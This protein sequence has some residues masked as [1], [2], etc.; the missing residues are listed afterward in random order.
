MASHFSTIGLAIASKEDFQALVQRICPLAEGLAAPGGVYWRWTDPC[1]A[2]VWIQVNEHNQLIGA[3][4]HYAGRSSVQVSLTARIPSPGPSELDGSFHGWAAPSGDAPD[5]GC[6]PFVFDAPDFRIHEGL[7]IPT[8]EAVQIAAFAHQIT[9]F[10]SVAAYEAGQSGNIPLYASQ[11]FIPSGLFTPA[12]DS[13]KPPLAHAIFTGHVVAAE[14]K[15]NAFTGRAFYSAFVETFGGSY[16]VVIDPDLL[17]GLPAPGGVI[18]GS[19]WL[20]GRIRRGSGSSSSQ[21]SGIRS[22]LARSVSQTIS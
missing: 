16:D 5:T 9:M 19:F 14:K 1:G 6:Y 2:E 21:N 18:S 10:E 15:I 4:V 7:A 12:G 22:T 17:P 8:R 11:S 3:N 13:R 20:S